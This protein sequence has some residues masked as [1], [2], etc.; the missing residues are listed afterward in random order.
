[1]KN[2]EIQFDFFL[3]K[4]KLKLATFLDKFEFKQFENERENLS[5]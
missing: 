1:M 3:L 2:Y 4:P 5:F